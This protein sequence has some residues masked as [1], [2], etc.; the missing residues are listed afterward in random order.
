[1]VPIPA[2]ADNPRMLIQSEG[3]L[4]LKRE[5]SALKD[6]FGTQLATH[7]LARKGMESAFRNRITP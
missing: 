2:R 5:A 6:D 7:R 4:G 3:D 1:M